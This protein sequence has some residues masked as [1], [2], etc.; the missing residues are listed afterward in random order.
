MTKLTKEN[1]ATNH[2]FLSFT[3]FSKFLTCEAAAAVNYRTPPT[4][5]LLLGS[6]IDAFFSEEIEEFKANNPDIFKKDGTLKS[7]FSAAD[8]AIKRIQSDV[9]MS[10]FLS[11]DKQ[12]IMQGEINGVPFKIKMDSYKEGEY[13]ADLKYMKDFSPVWIRGEKL[14]FIEAY[15]YDVEMALFQEIVYQKTGKKLPTYIVGITKETPSDVGVFQ[16]P[17]NQLD[18]AL[19]II[20]SR[21]PRI[22]GILKGKIQ[23]H[24]CEECEYCRKTKKARILNY[25]YAGMNGNQLR[26]SGIESDDPLLKIIKKEE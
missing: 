1:Y 5:A 25:V 16:I 15:N 11:G 14:N 8:E 2:D 19:D 24:R 9:V 23:P 18:V 13:I 21:L 3:R 17:Q 20:K 12:V 4:T 7:E 6:Y 26:E 10:Y 22:K